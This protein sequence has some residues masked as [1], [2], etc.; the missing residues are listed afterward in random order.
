V[1]D[2]AAVASDDYIAAMGRHASSVCLIT[3]TVGGE[4]FG[5]TAT[6]VT[7]VCAAPPRLLV[8]VNTSGL[9]HQK[10]MEAGVL[11][12]NVVTDTQEK[13]ARAFAGMMGGTF[14]RFSIG[15][16]SSLLT[17]APALG[18]AAAVFDCCIRETVRQFTHSIF[19]CEVVATQV[20]GGT[21]PL[22]YTGRRFRELRRIVSPPSDSRIE[23]D[24]LHF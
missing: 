14:D 5:L 22:L 23:L 24:G 19:I 6:A 1:P 17:G 16:W 21:E 4:R 15:E 2:F 11:C 18:G 10:I 9:T 7:S 3:T 20:Q 13:V 8:C 12:V